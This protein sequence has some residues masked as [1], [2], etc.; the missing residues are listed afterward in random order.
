MNL[1]RLRETLF[2]QEGFKLKPYRDSVGKLTIG[3]G[4][5]LDDVGISPGEAMVLL[6]A[7]IVRAVKAA[8]QTFPWF[9]D[10]DEERQEVIVNM[11]FNMGIG[12][13]RGFKKMIRAI[14]R[15]DY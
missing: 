8:S 5:N 3:V 15:G 12:N 13:L 7:D 6:E 2:L 10:L 1:T 11:V 9:E 14:E 4:R